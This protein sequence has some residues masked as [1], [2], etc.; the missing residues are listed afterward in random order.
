[1]LLEVIA[2]NL[3]DVK[4][5]EKYG[6]DRIE[7][8]PAMNELGITPSYGLIEAAVQAV[9]IPIN[10]IIRPHSQS[11]TY[12]QNDIETMKSDIRM[13]KK[14]GAN[15]IVIGPLTTKQTIDEEVLRELLDVSG[16]LEV[17]IHRAFDFARDQVEALKCLTKFKQ[18]TTILTAGGNYNAPDAVKEI[19][20][21]LDLSRDSH[22]SLMIG[23]GLRIES[24]QSFL[25]QVQG[26][27][28]AVHFGSGARVNNDFA[29]T[30][31]ESKIKQIKQIMT[32]A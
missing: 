18:I 13:V 26:E 29:Y 15:G 11:F 28:S 9:D 23:H 20:H 10:V 19:N 27:P 3:T 16:D 31:D 21:L 7:L 25:Q 2:I 12:N 22:L 24:F 1:M 4:D 6:A 32:S 5:A 17:T 14:L 8:S 30:L